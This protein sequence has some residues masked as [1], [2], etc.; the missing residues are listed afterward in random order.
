MKMLTNL[1]HEFSSRAGGGNVGGGCKAVHDDDLGVGVKGGPVK[2]EVD[3]AKLIILHLDL[4]FS[5][6]FL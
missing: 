2:V 6:S 3:D 1:F 4:G 5:L